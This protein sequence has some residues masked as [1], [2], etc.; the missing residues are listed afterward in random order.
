MDVLVD[1]LIGLQRQFPGAKQY[2]EGGTTFYFIP[3]LAMPPG[4]TPEH[5]DVLLCPTAR[6]GYPSRLFFAIR[7]EG[8]AARNWNGGD[9]HILGRQWYAFSWTDIQG[10]PLVDLVLSHVR[11]LLP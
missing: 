10:L 2:H 6:D 4:C 7:V 5:T 3:S 11:A 8:P 9:S 1:E